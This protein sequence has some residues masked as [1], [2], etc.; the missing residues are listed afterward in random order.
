MLELRNILMI[1]SQ[2]WEIINLGNSISLEGI[3]DQI[4]LIIVTN[5]ENGTFSCLKNI[6]G[7]CSVDVPMRY[8]Y[9]FV[10]TYNV[11]YSDVPDFIANI[12]DFDGVSF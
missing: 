2:R 12:K 1:D 7:P 4:D 8:M 5:D 10:K 9:D 6:F 11:D 3:F